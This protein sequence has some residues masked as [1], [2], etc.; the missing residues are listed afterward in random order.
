MELKA[1]I[2]ILRKTLFHLGFLG[3]TGAP[4]ESIVQNHLNIA[5]LDAF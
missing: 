3:K 1:T 5:L 4:N 2:Y